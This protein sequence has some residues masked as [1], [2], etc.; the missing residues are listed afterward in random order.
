MRTQYLSVVVYIQFS[1]G[2]AA[3]AIVNGTHLNDSSS[4]LTTI[5][6]PSET[7][8]MAENYL[9]PY[10]SSTD[11]ADGDLSVDTTSRAVEKSEERA[12]VGLWERLSNA[13]R[14]QQMKD[15]TPEQAFDR[16]QVGQ[17]TGKWPVSRS[18]FRKWLQ[19]VDN[20]QS[21]G[22]SY[23]DEYV[24]KRLI[25]CVYNHRPSKDGNTET[26]K[27]ME[28]VVQLITR[29][30]ADKED[31]ANGML[32]LLFRSNPLGTATPIM[33]AWIEKRVHPGVVCRILHLDKSNFVEI[34]PAY[35]I[36]WLRYIVKYNELENVEPYSMDTA[37]ELLQSN[38][39]LQFQTS[40]FLKQIKEYPEL[41]HAAGSLETLLRS[42]KSDLQRSK[43]TTRTRE[44]TD[45]RWRYQST[46]STPMRDNPGW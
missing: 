23:G 20:Y 21:E 33:D 45:D 28:I 41:E 22:T 37:V 34:L 43:T 15:W 38:M 24:V 32:Y 16:L 44:K 12:P 31:R 9:E 3:S 46:P 40:A 19:F 42:E 10:D 17:T 5:P 35:P 26:K 14:G 8:S 6:H 25:A 4:N 29:L 39:G 7:T 18:Q 30:L 11:K 2:T 1:E 36:L 13:F 27:P